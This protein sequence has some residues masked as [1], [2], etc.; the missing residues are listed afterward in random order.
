MKIKNLFLSA[1]ALT[2]TLFATSCSQD[3]LVKVGATGDLVT[4]QFT[5]T[6]PDGINTRAIG[7][8]TTANVVKCVVFDA[9]GKKMDLDQT[10]EIVGKKA[11]Y[12]VRFAKGQAYRVAFF[13]YNDQANAYN[14]T[15]L[16][17]IQVLGNQAC[18]MEN[19]DAFTAYTDITAEE[20]M[21]PINRTV[22]LYR[23]FAQLNF[24]AY[25]EDIEAARKAGVV[26]T[27]SQ[28]EVSDV[29]TAFSAY[30]NAVVG[31]TT[32]MTFAMN[33]I[34]AED[35]MVD[36]DN[37]GTYEPYE[38]L[39]LNYL[40]VGDKNQEKALTGVKFTWKTADGKT[41]VPVAEFKNVPVQRNY[42]TN[43]LGWLLTNPAEFNLV[44]D[45]KFEKPDYNVG[46]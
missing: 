16:K 36:L 13:A 10:L 46:I 6:T 20:T 44:I 26:V 29:Y 34:P 9:A 2:G 25:P 32:T 18:N 33:G 40:L 15:D 12:N 1:L 24:G 30:D 28:I 14:V 31:E 38:Y 39:A 41:N 35:L 8:G 27:N 4:A 22:T 7:D 21:S 3:G 19:R 17:N 45:E 11:T 5:I 42:R 43:I 23:P 37:D